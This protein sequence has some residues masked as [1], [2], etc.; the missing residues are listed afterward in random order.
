MINRSQAN[1]L[2]LILAGIFI[3]SLV[4][5][6]LIFKK[7][8]QIEIWV[9]FYGNYKFIQSVGILAYPITFVV[10]DILSEIYG[11]KKANRVVTSGLIA[12]LFILVVVT[13]ADYIPL[14][15]DQ[16]GEL[17]SPISAEIFNDVFG[18]SSAAIFASM[19]AYLFAQYIDIRIFHF[20]K[21]LTNGKHLWLRNNASTIFSQFI[22]TFLVLFLLFYLN[23]IP[24]PPELAKNQYFT[25]LLVNGFLFKV[26]FAAFD[27]PIIYAVTFY[28]RKRF[29]LKFG[30]EL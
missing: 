23:A 13:I 6:N 25:Q 26:F 21:K 14:A 24:I 9:P 7:F 20:W 16:N 15:V 11:Q 1:N 10:T 8:F 12:S 27:T 5:C 30:E 18:L 3:A 28:L 22:D 19:T 2:Y 17:L 4:S 29:N